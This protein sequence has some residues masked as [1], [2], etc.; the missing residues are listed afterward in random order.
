ME[1]ML[2]GSLFVCFVLAWARFFPPEWECLDPY[3]Q[4]LMDDVVHSMGRHRRGEK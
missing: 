2:C 3:T 4:I 1:C